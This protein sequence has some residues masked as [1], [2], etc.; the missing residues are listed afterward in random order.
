MRRNTLDHLRKQVL[1][2]LEGGR[3]TDLLGAQ[4]RPTREGPEGFF[5]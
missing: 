3:L 1:R 5:A 4:R 2:A